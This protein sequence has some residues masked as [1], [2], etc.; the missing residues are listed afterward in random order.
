MSAPDKSF[1]RAALFGAGT[2]LTPAGNGAV[3]ATIFRL[4][5]FEPIMRN[6]GY[7]QSSNRSCAAFADSSIGEY[8]TPSNTIGFASSF[9]KPLFSYQLTYSG[10]HPEAIAPHIPSLG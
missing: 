9:C 10:F 2:T 5:F 8:P 1:R 7:S 6:S 3:F 4:C